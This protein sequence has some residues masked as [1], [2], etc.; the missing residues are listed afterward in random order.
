MK[1][2]LVDTGVIGN[3]CSAQPDAKVRKWI[4]WQPENRLYLSILTLGEYRKSVEALPFG[5]PRRAALERAVEALGRRFAGRVLGLTDA[6]VLRWGTISGAVRQIKGVSPS[7]VDALMAA[8][9]LEH[10]L[11]YA[12]AHTER[13]DR[14]GVQVF[15][16]WKDDPGRFFVE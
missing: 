1:G 3:L 9:A 5:D 8:T 2:W 12:T 7:V 14:S 16:P 15:D 6:I 11:Y 13:V 10:D 4:E